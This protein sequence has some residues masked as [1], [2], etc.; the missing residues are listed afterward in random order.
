MHDVTL[1]AAVWLTVAC[2]C[3]RERAKELWSRLE[4]DRGLDESVSKM[5]FLAVGVGL[6][7]AAGLFLIQ[8]FNSAQDSVPDPVAPQP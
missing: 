1:P 5:I 6:A 7:I 3:G 2:H 4:D 8:T